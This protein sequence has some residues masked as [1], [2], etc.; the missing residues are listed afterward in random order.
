MAINEEILNATIV[1]L[2]GK[3]KSDSILLAQTGETLASLE[4]IRKDGEGNLPKDRG[5]GE[6]ITDVR[7]EEIYNKCKPKADMH[8]AR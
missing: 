1:A 5:T 6:K 2:E 3:I 8:L 7:R 4:S